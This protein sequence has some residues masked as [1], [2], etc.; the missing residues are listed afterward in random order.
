[1]H[2]YLL[3]KILLKFTAMLQDFYLDIQHHNLYIC[4]K[5][6]IYILCN[7]IL[8]SPTD[9]SHYEENALFVTL[10]SGQFVSSTSYDSPAGILFKD[11]ETHISRAAAQDSRLWTAITMS[12]RVCYRQR[13]TM[14]SVGT[15][16]VKVMFPTRYQHQLASNCFQAIKTPEK[17]M[18]INT[19]MAEFFTIL[20]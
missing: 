6:I 5:S 13:W 16:L 1:M 4:N 15:T 14:G 11:G 18:I 20:G 12:M 8:S 19:Q 10:N 17:G 7:C 2:I 9:K 3:F